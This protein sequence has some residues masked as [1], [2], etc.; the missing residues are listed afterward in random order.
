MSY[1]QG[2]GIIWVAKP[3]KEEILIILLEEVEE[4][5]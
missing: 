3:K 5:E 2:D 1:V 4:G